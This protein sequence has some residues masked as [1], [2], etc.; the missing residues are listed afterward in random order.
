MAV[1]QLYDEKEL[2]RRM[3]GGDEVAFRVFFDLYKDRVFRFMLSA[4]RSGPV[5][6]ELCHDVFL[7]IWMNRNSLTEVRDPAAYMFTIA[8]NRAMDHLRKAAA[9]TRFLDKMRTDSVETADIAGSNTTQQH[10]EASESDRLVREAIE[11]LSPQRRRVFQM[12]RDQGMDHEK[13]ARQLNISR[14]TV[15]NHLVESLRAI[16]RYLR[17]KN[18]DLQ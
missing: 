10:I 13:I 14:N 4:S 12:S 11:R 5:A 8:R 6:E 17:N 15:N 18:S 9:E 1:R 3:A 16:R 2:F 7:K